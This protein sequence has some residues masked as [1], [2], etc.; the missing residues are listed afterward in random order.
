MTMIFRPGLSKS[1]ISA[2]CMAATVHT[3]SAATAQFTAQRAASGVSWAP[4]YS[5][6]VNEGGSLGIGA[7]DN[8]GTPFLT[9]A[10]LGFDV[11][12]LAGQYAAVNSVTLTGTVRD[13]Y[14]TN[15]NPGTVQLFRIGN[16]HAA[17]TTP[18]TWAQDG[19][20]SPW[21]GGAT[22][23]DLETGS[24][25]ASATVTRGDAIGTVYTWTFSGAAAQQLVDDW[26]SG[27][28]SGLS[29]SD[30]GALGMGDYRSNIGGI[31]G[32]VA[33]PTLTIDFS[34]IPEPASGALAIAAIGL[35]AIRR[36]TV[37][38]A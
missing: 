26:T 17:W 33:Q 6:P 20:G 21:A 10:L 13:Q 5:I 14:P 15:G 24:A 22:M 25:L 30:T 9:A 29:L 8:G 12:S 18:A 35:M 2:T 38:N 32:T 28:N 37:R 11:S 4:S 31:Q 19:S 34:P 36:R 23:G 1:L 16:S 27:T 3:L 7:L